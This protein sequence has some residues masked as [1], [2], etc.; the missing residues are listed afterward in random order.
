ML[1][2]LHRQG[3]LRRARCV[4]GS[5][6]SRCFG[7]E[8]PAGEALLSPASREKETTSSSLLS[9]KAAQ[10]TA[11][12]AVKTNTLSARS[13]AFPSNSI[14]G[15]HTRARLGPPT[16]PR[17][18]AHLT[19]Y[20]HK[21]VFVSKHNQSLNVTA[22]DILEYV[23]NY[24]ET[25]S[26]SQPHRTTATHVILC[27]C[28]FCAKP[29]NGKSDNQYKLYVQ[30]GGGAYF[31]HRCG[32]GGS[33][34]D[35]KA[36]LGGTATTTEAPLTGR[37][38]TTTTSRTTPQKMSKQA[39]F[40][41]Y[42]QQRPSSQQVTSLPMPS[43]RL[44]ALYSSQLLD[45]PA[46]STNNNNQQQHQDSAACLKYLTE[47]RGL[48]MAT[49][50]RYGVGMAHYSFPST[51]DDDNSNNNKKSTWVKAACITFPW[52]MTV[53]D[54]KYQE[55]LR[56]AKFEYQAKNKNNNNTTTPDKST[57]SSKRKAAS[58]ESP[59]DAK[60]KNK[61]KNTTTFLT[62]R[63]KA[64]ALTQKSWQ[65][66]DPPGGGWGLFGYH[67][68][69]LDPAQRTQVVLCEGEYDAMAVWQATGCP[70]VSLPNGC[71][72]LP[73]QVLPLLEDFDKIYLWM[74]N[75]APG[76]EGAEQFCKK[77]GQDRCYLVRPTKENCGLTTTTNDDGVGLPKDANDA[78]RQGLDLNRILQDAQV[79]PHDSIVSFSELRDNVLH[80]IMYPEKYVGA[81]L[82]SL[83]KF[84]TLIKGLRRGELSVL[85]GATGSGKTTFLGQLSLDLA[86]QEMNVLWGSFEIKNTRLMH[87]LLQQHAREPL[88]AGDPAMAEKL[89][90]IAN[91][92]ESLPLHFLRFHGGS[93]VDDVLD[94][95]D[96][97][98]YVND[99]QHIILDNMQFMISRQNSNST[100]DKFDIQDVAIEKFRKFATDRNVHISL[101]VHPKKQEEDS[102]LSIASI[103][104]SAKAT[105]EADTVLI[106]QHEGG[107]KFLDVR[108]NRFNGELG[109]IPIFFDRR[110]CR[111][112]EV[113]P[114]PFN[115]KPIVPK[116]AKQVA[117]RTSTK[118]P[119]DHWAKFF[120]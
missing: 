5:S 50:R 91:R 58:S 24:S 40:Q 18:H 73:V 38:A 27:E 90:A 84:T 102:K 80:E 6:S 75:D 12:V 30:L 112:S 35:F 25:A 47:T 54:V 42:L 120:E 15:L 62:R 93:D 117:T 89:E 48:T 32:T 49:L 104:G 70:A 59:A 53:Q 82:P 119:T 88:P 101:V 96:Y 105:Q 97:A 55:E 21:S 7:G 95:M 87:K 81:P 37:R 61:N 60:N 66:L 115:G 92:F 69:P 4:Y 29:A 28:P 19:T 83:P 57:K 3:L 76:Q 10:T 68:L 77:I 71:R 94:A 64:R 17:H 103:Y 100:F 14:R 23:A 34:F 33:W 20:R 16:T 98:V 108:K 9:L 111:Y 46:H 78:L 36:R 116:I 8:S 106:L 56:G 114:V 74:D 51:D 1:R 109:H 45:D 72:S 107:K 31:C 22:K 110:S 118:A 86:E 11:T 52:L 113:P 63:I 39:R 79:V 26:S 85:T 65:R 41:S 44:Q 43:P 13:A 99:V 67:T 2:L